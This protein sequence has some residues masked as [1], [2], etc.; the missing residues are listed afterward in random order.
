MKILRRIYGATVPNPLNIT[1]P[2]WWINPLYR[3][4]YSNIPPG[5]G[6]AQ[7]SDL[8]EPAG[9]LYFAGEAMCRKYIGY[10]H[11]GYYSGIDVAQEVISAMNGKLKPTSNYC[12][13]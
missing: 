9:K 7:W 10:V 1:I 11:G 2:D 8:R 12:D 4:M 13:L 6:D 3:G 5:F